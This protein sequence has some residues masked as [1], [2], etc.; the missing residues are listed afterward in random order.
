MSDAETEVVAETAPAVIPDMTV[1]T[2][3]TSEWL[4]QDILRIPGLLPWG[5]Y[6]IDVAN[7][8]PRWIPKREDA[9]YPGPKE[10]LVELSYASVLAHAEQG[11]I[12]IISKVLDVYKRANPF[13]EVFSD[14][15]YHLLKYEEGE[16]YDAHCDQLGGREVPKIM[17][18]MM[19]PNDDYEGG[20][21]YFPRQDIEI[22]PTAGDVIV[23]PSGFAFPHGTKPVKSGTR[24]CVVSWLS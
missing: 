15:G 7:Q 10:I 9:G 11:L 3:S 2:I 14:S 4:T 24:Y 19:Y 13:A 17:T 6:L 22:K 5:D 23:F 20:E 16:C 18:V 12:K 8:V 21:V 1:P